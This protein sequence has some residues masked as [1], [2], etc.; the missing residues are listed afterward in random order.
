MHVLWSSDI[1]GDATSKNYVRQTFIQAQYRHEIGRHVK[2]SRGHDKDVALPSG[3]CFIELA[4]FCIE[5][6]MH[7]SLP[8]ISN[9]PDVTKINA[10]G[11]II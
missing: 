2:T 11:K 9:L 1:D 4:S 3:Q 7:D 8:K 10:N 5:H 6:M